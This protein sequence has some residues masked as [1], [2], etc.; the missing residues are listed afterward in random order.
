MAGVGDRRGRRLVRALG[1]GLRDLRV[2]ALARQLAISQSKLSRWERGQPPHPDLREAAVAMRVLGHDLVTK[3][4]PAGGALRDE[5]HAALVSRF[6]ARLPDHVPRRLEAPMP[7]AGDLRAWD[8]LLRLGSVR[9]GVAVE[10]RL[11]DW[12]ALLR[13]EHRK[14]R[15]SGAERLFLVLLDSHVNRRAVHDAGESLRQ[16]LPLDGRSVWRA[17]RTGRDPGASGLLFL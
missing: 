1:E 11:R 9:A 2:R 5:A 10:T 17:L 8:V 15:D 4:Y 12:Q 3:W 6:V 16:A 14:L 7:A 13:Q